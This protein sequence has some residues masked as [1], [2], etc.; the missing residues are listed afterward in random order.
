MTDRIPLVLRF[1][2]WPEQDQTAWTS[3]FS[4]GDFLEVDGA[5]ARWS[6]GTRAIRRQAYG[7]WL[8]FLFRQHPA[9]LAFPAA[10]R[11]TQDRVNAFLDECSERLMPRSISNIATSILSVAQALE[12]DRDWSWLTRP[13]RRLVQKAR[14]RSVAPAKPIS[15]ARIFRVGLRELASLT[16]PSPTLRQAVAFRS[17]LLMTFLI[18]RPVRRRALL[19]MTVSGHLNTDGS[20]MRVQFGEQDM[21]DGKARSF[22]LPNALNLPMQHYLTVV[23]PVLTAG[24][25]IDCVW[26]AKGGRCL[27]ADGIASDIEATTSRLLRMKLNPHSFR[28]I[29]ATSIAEIDPEHVGIIRDI[30]GHASLDMAER[31]YNR[32]TG[33]SSCNALQSI[34]EDIR[35]DVRKIQRVNPERASRPAGK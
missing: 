32:A 11:I 17:A 24:H 3:L 20:V 16:I 28:H 23:R 18:A 26:V 1:D 6:E 2:Q 29:A 34:V 5:A 13:V 15:A 22:P 19:A 14:T 7:Q 4:V 35:K 21:K 27:T 12:P 33:L 9:A 25:D 31:H 8:S 10:S 30:L